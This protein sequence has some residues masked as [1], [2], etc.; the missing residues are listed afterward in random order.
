[1]SPACVKCVGLRPEAGF[2]GEGALS[3]QMWASPAVAVLGIDAPPVA[4]A[5]HKIVPWARAGLSVRLAPGDEAERAYLALKEHLLAAIGRGTPKSTVPGTTR[6]AAPDRRV[7]PGLRRFPPRLRRHL[8]LRPGRG[9]QRRLAPAGAA[10][11]E[12]YPDMALLLTGVDDPE[13]KA[14]SENESVH[15]GELQKCCVNEA[16]LLGYL[17]AEMR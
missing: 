2:I 1:M 4:E 16:L 15:L 10:L 11:A 6:P 5:A 14:H 17:T 8:G 3:R 12:A 7:R 9:R 13:S